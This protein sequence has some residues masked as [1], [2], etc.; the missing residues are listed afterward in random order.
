[1]IR[2]RVT[3]RDKVRVRVIF[4]IFGVFMKNKIVLESY[5]ILQNSSK[6]ILVKFQ[7][8]LSGGF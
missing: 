6:H 7:L 8:N 1:M 3:V 2:V 5:P 4:V